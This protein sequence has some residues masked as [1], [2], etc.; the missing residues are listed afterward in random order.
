MSQS[1]L[2]NRLSSGQ[3]IPTGSILH[4]TDPRAKILGVFALLLS[5]TLTGQSSGLIAGLAVTFLL[6]LAAR[7]PLKYAIRGL[8]APL[9]FIFLLAVLQLFITPHAGSVVYLSW[10]F[11]SISAA[12]VHLSILLI[13][14]F[15]GL[16]LLLILA[17]TTLSTLE[18]IYGLDLLFK[19]L[20]VLGIHTQSITM[21]VQI[22]L[23]FIPF[24][25]M[26]TEN[27]TRSQA[28]R[29]ALW[30]SEQGNL[31]QRARQMLPLLI[32]LF[33]TSLQQADTLTNAML[34]RGYG[35]TTRRTGLRVYSFKWKDGLF[36][37]LCLAACAAILY[38]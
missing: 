6:L 35:S 23:R 33:T 7:I 1:E 34:A 25:A 18:L 21:V 26:R 19:L 27:I 38:L 37:L 13:L 20:Q 10:W 22:M 30:G 17:G 2:L 24:L 12:G 31:I 36:L 29:G 28:A 11:L 15:L 32:P 3:Y 5:I 8:L 4:R 14:R 16:L 9:P